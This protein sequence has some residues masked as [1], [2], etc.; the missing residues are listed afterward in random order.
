[1]YVWLNVRDPWINNRS[2]GNCN[3]YKHHIGKYDECHHDRH[4]HCAVC[5]HMNHGKRFELGQV[6]HMHNMKIHHWPF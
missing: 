1:M 3:V 2:T 4:D 6:L 5:Y